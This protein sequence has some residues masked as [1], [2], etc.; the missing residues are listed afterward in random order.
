MGN[1]W[2]ACATDLHYLRVYSMSGLQMYCIRFAKPI[3]T[4]VGYENLLVYVYHDSL[5]VLGC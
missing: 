3:V 1:H 4:L 5:P 2:V